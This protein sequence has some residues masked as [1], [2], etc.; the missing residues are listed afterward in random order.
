MF[1]YSRKNPDYI[2]NIFASFYLPVAYKHDD[3]YIF[4]GSSAALLEE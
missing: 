2:L 3:L 1:L 4:G